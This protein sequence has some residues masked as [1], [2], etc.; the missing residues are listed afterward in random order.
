MSISR[1]GRGDQ[2]VDAPHQHVLLVGHALA[3]DQQGMGQLQVFAVLDEV[4]GHLQRQLA[5]RLQDQA[6]RHA[7]AGAAAGQDVE[8]RQGEAGGLAGAGLRAAE[9]VAAHQHGRDRL[10][11]DRRGR[12]VALLGDGAHDLGRQAELGKAVLLGG[13]LVLDLCRELGSVGASASVIGA[14][15]CVGSGSSGRGLRHGI[16]HGVRGRQRPRLRMQV[17]IRVVRRRCGRVIGQALGS[18]SVWAAART[19][20]GKR[21]QASARQRGISRK[22]ARKSSLLRCRACPA[23]ASRTTLHETRRWRGR[24]PSYDDMTEQ[25]AQRRSRTT[26]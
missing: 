8:H 25:P 19:P 6:A 22:S 3:A 26:P 15:R 24:R 11:L 5:R 4:L 23:S 14:A 2:H 1:P 12:A 9:H 21:A 10:R 7:G 16:G 13:R 18:R 17:R 20:V